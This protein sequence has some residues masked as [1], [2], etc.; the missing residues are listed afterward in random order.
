MTKPDRVAVLTIVLLGASLAPLSSPLAGATSSPRGARGTSPRG[1]T[2]TILLSGRMSS[3]MS[4]SMTG[5]FSV[6]HALTLDWDLPILTPVR[7]NGYVERVDSLSYTFDVPPA[8]GAALTI[9]GR[10]VRRYHWNAPPADTVIHLLERLRVTVTSALSPF[11]SRAHYP[12]ALTQQPAYDG[13]RREPCPEA[14][15]WAASCT[16]LPC[17]PELTDD[18]V[19]VVIAALERV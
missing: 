5:A 2:G 3:K 18:E 8:S 4:L 17:F 14:E 16:S 13:F 10:R 15:A 9:A 7:S 1:I 12:L 19:A 11:R 6:G